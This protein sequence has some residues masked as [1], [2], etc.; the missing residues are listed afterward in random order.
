MKIRRI[1]S[2][3]LLEPFPILNDNLSAGSTDKLFL[4]QL[5]N[6]LVYVHQR[7]AK[8]ISEVLLGSVEIKRPSKLCFPDP[9]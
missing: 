3:Y 1:K 8:R 6:R 2:C 7:K 4:F 5:G 9:L